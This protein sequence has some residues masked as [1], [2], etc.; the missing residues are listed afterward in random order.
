VNFDRLEDMP[1]RSL[2]GDNLDLSLSFGQKVLLVDHRCR[3]QPPWLRLHV[4]TVVDV[5]KSQDRDDAR[6]TLDILHPRMCIPVSLN[7]FL[8][9]LVSATVLFRKG[10]KQG[11]TKRWERNIHRICRNSALLGKITMRHVCS[12]MSRV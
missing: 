10:A 1:P 2:R 4:E 9:L 8:K 11:V 5:G 12:L 3:H 7:H 6:V